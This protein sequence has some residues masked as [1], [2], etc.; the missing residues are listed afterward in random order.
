MYS[1]R[2]VQKNSADVDHTYSIKK[3]YGDAS[4]F[5]T[6]ADIKKAVNQKQNY[7]ITDSSFNRSKGA[8]TNTEYLIKELQHGNVILLSGPAGIGKTHLALESAKIFAKSNNYDLKIIHSN[9]KSIYQDLI[10]TFPDESNYMVVVDDADQL[11][12]LHYLL[13]LSADSQRHHFIKIIITVRDYAR[14]KLLKAIRT[15]LIPAQYEV[16]ALSDDNI[17]KVLSDNLGIQNDNLLDQIKLIA[18][19]N[20][21]LAIMAGMCAINGEFG[22][23][24]NAFDIFNDYYADIIDKFDR[25]EILVATIIAFF[26]TFYLKETEL[27][28]EIAL[29]HGID[30]VQFR[31][32]CLSLHRKE[33]VSIDN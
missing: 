6:E 14:E 21:R 9:G 8:K 22:S 19:G 31:N 15:V 33:V 20:I 24:R 18:K 7:K 13:E 2:V 28:F 1:K 16:H 29:Q 27:P 11:T 12:E 17:M 32:I 4:I 30:T 5:N 25:N 3:A 23:I 26:D 10:V